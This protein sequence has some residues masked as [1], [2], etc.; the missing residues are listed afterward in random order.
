M[1]ISNHKAFSYYFCKL[2]IFLSNYFLN[3]LRCLLTF[4]NCCV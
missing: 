4:E 3:I 2:A 1:R